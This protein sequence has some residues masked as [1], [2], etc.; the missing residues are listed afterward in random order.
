MSKTNNANIIK[1]S[2]AKAT[3][4]IDVIKKS[5]IQRKSSIGRN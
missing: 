4:L 3:P 1:V 5:R 2:S